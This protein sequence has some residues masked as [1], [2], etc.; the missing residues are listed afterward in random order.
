MFSII[1]YRVL[2]PDL[3]VGVN[4]SEY[5]S[6]NALTTCVAPFTAFWKDSM[7]SSFPL[8]LFRL[9]INSLIGVPVS[10]AC[11]ARLRSVFI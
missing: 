11:L 3:S 2:S 5:A 10:S 6:L 1:L 8:G 4:I 7:R 9:A